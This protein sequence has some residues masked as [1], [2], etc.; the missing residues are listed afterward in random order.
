MYNYFF[1]REKEE[2][3]RVVRIAWTPKEESYVGTIVKV[4]T[5]KQTACVRWDKQ[6]E[7]KVKLYNLRLVG[8]YLTG[9]G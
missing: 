3:S 2:G 5:T 9:I 6:P 4:N 7:D 8:N 1:D